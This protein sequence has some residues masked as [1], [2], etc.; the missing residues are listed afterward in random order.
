VDQPYFAPAVNRHTAGA[1]T[2]EMND[3]V[4]V[5]ALVVLLFP[6]VYFMY[7]NRPAKLLKSWLEMENFK[8]LKSERQRSDIGPFIGDARR[9][10][11]IYQVTVKDRSGAIREG[12]VR[13]GIDDGFH[14]IDVRW[15]KM[16]SPWV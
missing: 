10:V 13:F 5:V 11:A 7:R 12:W 8:L 16:T 15:N 2:R 14:N 9:T 4:L 6:A 3:F 1:R